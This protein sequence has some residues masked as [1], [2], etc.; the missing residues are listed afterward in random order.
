MS[1]MSDPTPKTGE[2]LDFLQRYRGDEPIVLTAIVPNGGGIES[3]TFRPESEGVRLRNWIDL[4][5][6]KANVY[7]TV[8]P[9]LK[10]LSGRVKA[11]KTD[12]RGMTTLHVDVDPRIG[13]DF[14][15]ERARIL[16][17]FES[18]T[19]APTIIIDSGGGY[20]AFWVLD[21]E[22][23][24]NGSEE[25]AAELEAYNQQLELL[26]HADPC[27]NIDRIMRLPGTLNVPDTKKLKKG[28]AVAL[29][30][31]VQYLD[32][33]SY[34]LSKFTAAPR[35]QMKGARTGAPVKLSG[36]LPRI[37]LDTL[38]EKVSQKAKVIIIHGTDPD[39]PLR[40]PS[41][42]EALFYICCELARAEVP[43][44]TI[45]AII[46][47]RDLAISASVLEKPRAAEYA[48]RQIQ[49]AKEEAESPELRELNDNHAVISDIG[50][51]CRV[52]SENMDPVM[53]RTRISEQSFD[54]FRNRYMNRLVIEGKNKT[55]LGKWW[56]QHPKRRQYDSIVF[57]PGHEVEGAYNLWRGFTCEAIPGDWSLLKAHI[58]NNICSGRVEHFEYLLSWMARTVQ[59]PGSP[60]EVSIVLRGRMGTGKGKFAKAF[61]SLWGRHFLQITDPKH[62][63]GNFNAHLRD[64][65]VLFADEAFYAGDKKHES[66]LKALITEETLVVEGKH[67]N[68]EAA[69]NF[70]H[71][72]MASNSQW[73]VPAGSDERRFFVLEVGDE[74][75]QDSP[76]FRA[77]D[78]ELNSGGREAMLY[79]LLNRDLS[80]FDVRA[81]P[82]TI[83]LQEQKLLSWREEESWWYEKLHEGRLLEQG[84]PAEVLKHELHKDYLD[85][86]NRHRLQ[87]PLHP[88]AFGRFLTRV[89]PA[90]YP[91]GFQ[92]LTE[93][94]G[95]DGDDARMIKARA[96]W[97]SLPPLE[98]CREFWDKNFGGPWNWPKEEEDR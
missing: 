25:L 1:F 68:A 4:W 86:A 66:I 53:L 57:S 72:L 84:W 19:P 22:H 21:Q 70:T 85:F 9:T 47:D 89:M 54:D 20:Q 63:V 80:D 51:R 79:D 58:L 39:D 10:R 91:R 69:A 33:A 8:N 42:S 45:A 90:G 59:K 65:V 96:Y 36:N 97:Y 40:F 48:A 77:I 88:T 73:V 92:R 82:R 56:L 38:P 55:P 94:V 93:I 46:M 83:A 18:F 87:R 62:L 67:V 23:A 98:D 31:L 27:H 26:F 17:M 32:G 5:Q 64:C 78:T 75:M 7:F 50:G 12:M 14:A 2:A 35:L 60:G 95:Y 76:Y 28:R 52:I 41:R 37:D 49:R 13:E 30:R 81:F 74:S 6:G 44:D 24:V 3:E 15:K 16:A 11:A 29:A 43:D 34:P 61:G 71:L